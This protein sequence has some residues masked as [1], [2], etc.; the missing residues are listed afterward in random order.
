MWRFRLGYCG[1]ATFVYIYIYNCLHV[2][3]VWSMCRHMFCTFE[4]LFDMFWQLFG[5]LFASFEH[6]G[7]REENSQNSK[8]NHHTCYLLVRFWGPGGES[9]GNQREPKGNQRETKRRQRE[10]QLEPKRANRQPKGSQREPKGAN[11]EPT[12]SHRGASE[13]PQAPKST[14]VCV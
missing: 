1:I 5:N 4:H 3:Y 2:C 6:F 9:K 8:R 11:R 14:Q 13:A 12:G 7:G 10:S